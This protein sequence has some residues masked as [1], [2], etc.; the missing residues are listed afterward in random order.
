MAVRVDPENNETRALFALER[1]GEFDFLTY[2][3][4]VAELADFMAEA[5]AY[6]D[7][8]I[9]EAVAAGRAAL[10][11]RLD[12]IQRSAGA[13]AEV[14]YRERAQIARLTPLKA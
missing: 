5:N 4:S 13:G 10:D 6:D 3:S 2:G 9:D 12:A 1:E 11:A 7:S 14:V 8:P